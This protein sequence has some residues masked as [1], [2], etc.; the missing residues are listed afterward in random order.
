MKKLLLI[1]ATFI[2]INVTAQNVGIGTTTPAYKL[3]VNGNLNIKGDSSIYVSGTKVLSINGVRNLFLGIGSGSSNTTGGNNT[4]QGYQALYSNLTGISNIANGTWAL[5]S[6]T[7]GSGNSAIGFE[8][9][10]SN[11]SG[12][13]N[14]ALG[15]LALTSN[16]IGNYNVG[17]GWLA[18]QFT[19]TSSGNTALGV[20]AGDTYNNG[21][22]NTFIGY[23][24]SANSNYFTNS[25]ALG[26]GTTISSSNQMR[27]GN[28]SVTSI[29]GQVGW[30]T[31]SD[32]RVKTNIQNNVQGL[33]FIL[34][35]TPVTYTIDVT[36]LDKLL[37]P[38][39]FKNT[40]TQKELDA[41]VAKSKIV[42]TGFIAQDVEAIA[43]QVGYDFSGVD[44]PKNDKDLYGIRYAE[45][46]VPL[47]K[48]VQELS[49]QNEEQQKLI[50]LLTQRI[51]KLENK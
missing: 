13:Y 14:T 29:G 7:T 19:I 44:A 50:L 5:Y 9:Q 23:G 25:V 39:G 10:F 45:F 36:I 24:S 46:V 26:S 35:L 16:T 12:N 42:Y 31:I 38:D 17:I 4:T 2:V 40:T 3:D 22:Y 51:E 32:A 48:A 47:V 8:T 30:T 27:F 21:N 6:N 49:K 11:T 20:S 34:K 43:K 15:Y 1:A 33:N 41:K 28:S 37:R 18:N